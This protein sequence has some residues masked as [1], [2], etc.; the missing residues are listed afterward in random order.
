MTD[1]LG[2]LVDRSLSPRQGLRARPTSRFANLFPDEAEPAV[3][4]RTAEPKHEHTR[5]SAERRENPAPPKPSSISHQDPGFDDRPSREPAAV[6]EPARRTASKPVEAPGLPPVEAKTD[7]APAAVDPPENTLARKAVPEVPPPPPPLNRAR[8][9]ILEATSVDTDANVAFERQ[10]APPRPAKAAPLRPLRP[11]AGPARIET[12]TPATEP[13]PDR[14]PARAARGTTLTARDAPVS[15][16]PLPPAIGTGLLVRTPAPGR[17]SP[18]QEAA[19]MPASPAP[20]PEVTVIIHRL[21]VRPPAKAARAEPRQAK[22]D[23]DAPL[24][25]DA[26]LKSRSRG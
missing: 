25:L 17:R 12:V 6:R 22:R 24:S 7:Q 18:P 11:A 4:E 16:P 5:E 14:G 2:R 15:P 23:P 19:T 13:A 8:K 1:F 3:I 26:Y 10:D 21:E 9:A 20:T